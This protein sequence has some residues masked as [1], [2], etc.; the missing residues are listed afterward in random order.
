MRRRTL[1]LW[2]LSGICSLTLACSEDAPGPTAPATA[3]PAATLDGAALSL[4]GIGAGAAGPGC[5]TAPYRQ[6]DFWLGSWEV[7]VNGNPPRAASFITSEL[8]GCVILENWHG[9]LG[10][11]GRSL[12]GFDAA[13]GQWHQHWV[14]NYG[15]YPLRLDGGLRGG[16][17]V[18]QGSYPD[19]S[20]TPTVFTDRYTWTPLGPDDVRQAAEQ[21]VDGGQTFGPVN[22]DGR[23][24]RN[25]APTVP[26]AAFFGV[27]ASADPTW[28]LF[29]EFDFLVGA[30]EVRLDGPGVAN[31]AAHRSSLRSDITREMD[32]CLLEERIT[33]PA[34]YE[35]MVFLNIRP[36]DEIWQRTYMDNRGLR[37]F[38]T[39][40]RMQ[41]GKTIL[42]GTMPGPGHGVAPVRATFEELDSN[43]FTE[44]WERGGQG[45]TWTPLL[46]ATYGR[47]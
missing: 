12:N 20:G 6:F 3:Q 40:P 18:M 15:F 8:D 26:P 39:G 21:S 11:T 44:R 47:R 34:G 17:M 24:H 41:D 36:L 2:G 4:Y 7:A 42:T 31:G 5:R 27:C 9:A 14:E 29:H 38:V 43:H 23:Y 22:F 32:G 35:A 16:S 1:L 46:T 10:G 13:D 25:P 28:V 45:G 33:G 19:P 37:I 30:W